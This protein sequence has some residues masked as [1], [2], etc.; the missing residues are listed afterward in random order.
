MPDSAA[1]PFAVGDPALDA[2]G[3]VVEVGETHTI[4]AF[5]TNVS[6][7]EGEIRQVA[8]YVVRLDNGTTRSVADRDGHLVRE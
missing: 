2:A 3:E 7:P 1:G 4:R 8:T 5:G 6:D